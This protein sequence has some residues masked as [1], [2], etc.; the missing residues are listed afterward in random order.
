MPDYIE[1]RKSI[2][3]ELMSIKD[4]VRSF[5]SHWPEDG[6][7]KEIILRNVL[8]NHLPLNVA[9]GTGFIVGE[10]QS[11]RLIETSSQIDIIVYSNSLPPL[12]QI[13]DLVVVAKESVLGIIEVKTNLRTQNINSIFKKAHDN[14]ALIGRNSVFNGIFCFEN[15]SFMH[16]QNVLPDRLATALQKYPGYINN[17]SFGKDLFMKYWQQGQPYGNNHRNHYSFYELNDLSFG[18]FVSNLVEDC[19]IQLNHSPI[20]QTFQKYL[21]PIEGT[22]EVKRIRSFEIELDN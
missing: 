21:Y 19:Y 18:Y 10:S 16:N 9:L 13:D 4:R 12:F 2:S 14:G 3:Q 5:V 1:Y 20:S 6:R 22:K 15:S 17:V 8:R 7:Y 11:A